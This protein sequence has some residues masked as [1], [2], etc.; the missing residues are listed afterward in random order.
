MEQKEVQTRQQA[1]LVNPYESLGGDQWSVD[2]DHILPDQLPVLKI[3]HVNSK[4]VPEDV[5]PGKL[6]NTATQ[7]VME[8]FRGVL[9][10]AR[11]GQ[12][13][14]PE[15]YNAENGHLCRST[16]GQKPYGDGSDPQQGP[17][18]WPDGAGRLAGHCP[19]LLWR[20]EGDVSRPPRCATSYQLLMWELEGDAGAIF[21]VMRRA[22]RGFQSLKTRLHGRR[23]AILQ[24]YEAKDIEGIPYNVLAP[25]EI[26]AVK[27]RSPRGDYF[28]PKFTVLDDRVDLDWAR[29][30]TASIADLIQHVRATDQVG[31][32][33]EPVE[34][35]EMS[36]MPF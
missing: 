19:W 30:L 24:R 1:T 12:V 36:G 25:I 35:G 28:I 22:A 15:E 3:T 6:C 23:H 21:N 11:S 29:S 18:R 7:E 31:G 9:L 5:P 2:V 8:T 13:A 14:F 33:I 4:G 27:E 20:C 32:P 16:D 34:S 10:Y 17:C 26:S